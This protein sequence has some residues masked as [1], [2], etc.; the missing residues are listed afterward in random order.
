MSWSVPFRCEELLPNGLIECLVGV[1]EVVD[2]TADF[3]HGF[4]ESTFVDSRVIR[5]AV[6]RNI[7]I[8]GET[9]HQVEVG[10]PEFAERHNTIP[11]RLAYDM[12]NLLAH[13]YWK[14]EAAIIWEAATNHVPSLRPLLVAALAEAERSN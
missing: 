4:S 5:R 12:R 10:Y 13:S 14:S 3:I 8:I 6:E 7:E 2:D 9:L 1:I 11:Y